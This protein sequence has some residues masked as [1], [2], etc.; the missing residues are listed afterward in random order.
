M[1]RMR[2]RSDQ[3]MSSPIAAAPW[4]AR[5]TQLAHQLLARPLFLGL[6]AATLVF[7][8]FA[9]GHAFKLQPDDGSI[10]L[11]GRSTLTILE[12]T[13]HADAPPTPL[14]KND[15][16]LGIA[17]QHVR[18]PREAARL[19]GA[20]QP[21]TEVPYLI[22]RAGQ[23]LVVTVPLT[24]FR[25]ADRAYALSILL[26]AVYLAIGFLVY[27]KSANDRP[28]RLFFLLCLCFAVYFMTDLEHPAYDWS[29]MLRRNGG[30]FA[31]F[32]L[33]AIFLHFFLVFP[34]RKQFMVRR[35]YLSLAIY[36]MPLLFY[37]DFTH[38]QFHGMRAA[39]I[40][41]VTWMILGLYYLAGLVVLMNSYFSYRDPLL[42]ERVRILTWGTLAAVLPFLVFK[43]GL[44]EMTARGDLAQLGVLPLAA[45]PV[46]FGYSVARYQI[47][48]IDFLVKRSL[49]F[50]IATGLLLVAWGALVLWIGSSLV[51]MIGSGNPLFTVGVT[52]F[53]AA[54]LWPLRNQMQKGLEVRLYRSRTNLAVL[55]EQFSRDIPGLIQQQ[56]LLNHVGRTLRENLELPRLWF[57]LPRHGDPDDVWHRAWPD[58]PA[59]E[60]R[61]LS[62]TDPVPNVP[63]GKIDPAPQIEI[64]LVL[65][66]IAERQEPLWID[67]RQIRRR[68]AAAAPPGG[69][70]QP[71]DIQAEL[72][73]LAHNGLS[74]LVP[75]AVSGRIIGL[76]ALPSRPG[77]ETY[78]LHE[79]QL[80]TI[81]ARQTAMQLENTRLYAQELAKQTLEEEMRMARS[82]QSRLLPRTIPEIAGV[83]IGAVNLSSKT[84]SGDYYDLIQREDGQIVMVI[85]D[86][87]GK[88]MPASLLASNLQASLRAQCDHW[89]SPGAILRRVNRQ[90]HASTDS[91]HFATAFLAFLDPATMRLRY[92]TGG[93]DAPILLTGSGDLVRLGE[94]GLP[95]GAFDFG[96]YE[97]GQI[98][99][100]AGDL[101]LLYTDGLTETMSPDDQELYGTERL[102]LFLRD[103][104]HLGTSE[105][106]SALD[107]ELQRF[108]GRHE[109]DDDITLI[110]LKVF[111]ALQNQRTGCASPAS[112]QET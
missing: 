9:A 58:L 77:D 24:G 21:G 26:A 73:L 64:P 33:P 27:A 18:S 54:V 98:Q 86:V 89:D 65:L 109:A 38:A 34:E 39:Q 20:Q 12:P 59:G 45:I 83:Q 47:L 6:G 70:N 93:H 10:W 94:G 44:G 30:A 13:R 5:L 53:A 25:I 107:A 16:I 60:P 68:T 91:R 46:C 28:A 23:P 111:A 41:A 78:Q 71:V 84:V 82:I 102:D 105:L 101:L 110:T 72:E 36:L 17:N 3:D 85:A 56:A 55:L 50:N 31:R 4:L 49:L 67:P 66:D 76:I 42:R 43:I 1:T 7:C 11:H 92:S 40:G 74:L 97:E 52:L 57:Y 103:N 51:T 100:K 88:G 32:L 104:R 48:Q 112:S 19:L 61:L 80:L 62:T 35:P 106:L 14:R 90:L 2:R 81:I 108:R 29:D 37:A 63:V 87:S 69:A 8:V 22:E 75:M 96:D 99:L 79:I 95:L 15:I